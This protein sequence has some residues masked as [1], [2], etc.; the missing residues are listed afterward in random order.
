ML[1]P[2]LVATSSMHPSIYDQQVCALLWETIHGYLA[3]QCA[4]LLC[5]NNDIVYCEVY[6]DNKMNYDNN[7]ILLLLYVMHDT[8]CEANA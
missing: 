3:I 5:I 6:Y 2:C 1:G 8:Y 4:T 7:I